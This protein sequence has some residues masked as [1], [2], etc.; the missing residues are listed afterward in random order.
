MACDEEVPSLH[1]QEGVGLLS[2]DVMDDR[3]EAVD[4]EAL[5]HVEVYSF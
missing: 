2:C 4:M 3:E 1:I 5:P